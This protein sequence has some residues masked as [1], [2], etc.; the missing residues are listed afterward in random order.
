M[1]NYSSF[2][3]EEVLPYVISTRKRPLQPGDARGLRRRRCL[4]IGSP[5]C[6]S[7]LQEERGPL[8]KDGK[9]L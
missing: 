8:G 7:L 5:N 9:E 3:S 1:T 4:P 2:R 6:S